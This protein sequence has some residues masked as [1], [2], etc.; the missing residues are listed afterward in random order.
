MSEE[1]YE[2]RVERLAKAA[3]EGATYWCIE[4]DHGEQEPYEGQIADF[5]RAIAR[6]IIAS[7][8][9]AGYVC[10]PVDLLKDCLAIISELE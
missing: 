9:E 2:Q 3:Y 4:N 5:C 7:D 1:T 6:A 10:T 8:R